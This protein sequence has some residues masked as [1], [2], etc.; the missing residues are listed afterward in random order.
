M[1]N[2]AKIFAGGLTFLLFFGFIYIFSTFTFS[3]FGLLFLAFAPYIIFEMFEYY[4]KRHYRIAVVTSLVLGMIISIIYFS[5]TTDDEIIWI[6]FGNVLLFGMFGILMLFL[7]NLIPKMLRWDQK[8]LIN[9]GINLRN[10]EQYQDSLKCFSN[11]IEIDPKYEQVWFE[12][13]ITF[14]NLGKYQEAETCFEKDREIGSVSMFKR[15]Q[16]QNKGLEL[17]GLGYYEAGIGYYDKYLEKKPGSERTMLN[18][19]AALLRLE[20]YD[21]ALNTCNEILNN[22]AKFSGAWNNK[23]FTL[24]KLK[25]FD[26][27][28]ECID[29]SLK[30][31]SKNPNTL[32]T[33]G[34]ILSEM[35]YYNE[36]LKYHNNS[37]QIKDPLE[38][39]YIKHNKAI[40]RIVSR[41]KAE[42]WSCKGNA[43]KGLGENK[44]AEKCYNKALDL[45]PELK[46]A[47]EGLKSLKNTK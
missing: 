36:A 47:K 18:K 41:N 1:V 7:A 22:N 4:N 13:G 16:W 39:W 14:L 43:F 11:A 32:N 21:E 40:M 42:R 33:K 31:N 19:S 35:G 27:A 3:F 8:S 29:E 25:N 28:L 17:I 20:K 38:K 37:L 44:E 10:Q 23:A 45:Y 34:W 12:R 46:S 9:E 15:L 5:V 6:I 24:M 26:E 2:M 30:L